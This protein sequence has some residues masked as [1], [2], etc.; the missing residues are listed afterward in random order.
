MPGASDRP[1]EGSADVD[2]RRNR[3]SEVL[4]IRMG[5]HVLMIKTHHVNNEVL[6]PSDEAK[7]GDIPLAN[8]E[9]K[10]LDVRKVL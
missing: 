2:G 1:L 10:R 8:K 3:E 5:C 7:V 4:V 6:D 9:M